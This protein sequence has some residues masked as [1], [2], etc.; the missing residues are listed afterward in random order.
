VPATDVEP[1]LD[2]T[3]ETVLVASRTLVA[4]S[5]QSIAAVLDEVDVMQVRVLVVVAS[6]GPC[7]LGEVAEAVG[8]HV[9][10]ASRT[11]DRLVSM[12]LLHRAAS[13]TDR[14]NL[15]L[16]LTPDGEALVARVLRERR[17]ALRPVLQRL[18]PRKQRR[19]T[20]ALRDF[21]QAAGEP[22]DRALWAMGWT[23]EPQEV[24][25]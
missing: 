8:L 7:S 13:A 3:L 16:T 18:G 15:E 20:A 5:A 22:A 25:P 4:I 19:L 1:D 2:E 14:R 23:T 6:R 12:G 24:S 17:D 21:A 9:S 10:T 11:C